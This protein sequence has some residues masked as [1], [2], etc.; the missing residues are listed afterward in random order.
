MKTRKKVLR[1]GYLEVNAP[2]CVTLESLA[3]RQVETVLV[4]I[5]EEQNSRIS[6][7]FSREDYLKR[8]KKRSR[9]TRYVSSSSLKKEKASLTERDFI[10]LRN[11]SLYSS[12]SQGSGFLLSVEST[13][14]LQPSFTERESRLLGK[15]S[16]LSFASIYRQ[17]KFF[18]NNT[19]HSYNE[20]LFYE[21]ECIYFSKVSERSFYILTKDETGSVQRFDFA[22]PFAT[23]TSL[24]SLWLDRF[25]SKL[26]NR[27]LMPKY[28]LL[29]V[30]VAAD[31]EQTEFEDL[32]EE[33]EARGL[34]VYAVSLSS[35]ELGTTIFEI[36]PEH[37][38]NE[39]SFVWFCFNKYFS[40]R[41]FHKSHFGRLLL[42]FVFGTL[43]GTKRDNRVKFLFFGRGAGQ[44]RRIEN[45]IRLQLLKKFEDIRTIPS[46]IFLHGWKDNSVTSTCEKLNE[47]LSQSSK[48]SAGSLEHGIVPLEFSMVTDAKGSCLQHPIFRIL[49]EPTERLSRL[50]LKSSGARS[51]TL[52]S[53]REFS[54][55]S[56]VMRMSLERRDVQRKY[57]GGVFW[58]DL[59]NPE[60]LSSKD[61]Q[62][63]KLLKYIE[64]NIDRAS[65][66]GYK[67][68]LLILDSLT[69]VE[70]LPMVF[71]AL[72]KM[73]KILHLVVIRSLGDTILSLNTLDNW[74][75]TSF[76]LSKPDSSEAE[77]N[78]QSND[79][80]F[81]AYE[82]SNQFTL[83]L[84]HNFLMAGDKREASKRFVT[85][86][87]K[88]LHEKR[89]HGINN[90]E[91]ISEDVRFR[92]SFLSFLTA[93]SLERHE[94]FSVS[95]VSVFFY[96]Q[97]QMTEYD[98][99]NKTVLA[100]LNFFS[101]IKVIHTARY[102]GQDIFC[103]KL[104]LREIFDIKRSHVVKLQPIFFP[105]RINE[106]FLTEKR[107]KKL[108]RKSLEQFFLRNSDL[109]DTIRKSKTFYIWKERFLE[110]FLRVDDY[111]TMLTSCFLNISFLKR[112][113]TLKSTKE[114]NQALTTAQSA[115][116]CACI[117]PRVHG[118][119]FEVCLKLRM[120]VAHLIHLT[121]KHSNIDP[122]RALHLWLEGFLTLFSNAGSGEITGRL[123]EAVLAFLKSI[124]GTSYNLEKVKSSVGFLSSRTGL[125]LKE[126]K[127][128]KCLE[129]INS[130]LALTQT[131]SS[132]SYDVLDMS[133]VL[134]QARTCKP[135]SSLNPVVDAKVINS[136]LLPLS[137]SP[138]SEGK[139]RVNK[140]QRKKKQPA[141]SNNSFSK[142]F[143]E[144]RSVNSM[145]I[146]RHEHSS[147]ARAR[148]FRTTGQPKT[149]LEIKVERFEHSALEACH[150]ETALGPGFLVFSVNEYYLVYS[151][152]TSISNLPTRKNQAV[153]ATQVELSANSQF[154][155]KNKKETKRRTTTFAGEMVESEIS[156]GKNARSRLNDATPANALHKHETGANF[157]LHGMGSSEDSNTNDFKIHFCGYFTL[158]KDLERVVG[159]K[160]MLRQKRLFVQVC[161]P[162]TKENYYLMARID[163]Y[164]NRV[165]E[166][167]NP[168]DLASTLLIRPISSRQRVS[169]LGDVFISKRRTN[170]LYLGILPEKGMVASFYSYQEKKEIILDGTFAK[171]VKVHDVSI[172]K[173]MNENSFLFALATSKFLSFVKVNVKK[174][175]LVFEI[176]SKQSLQSCGV[177]SRILLLEKRLY[178][179]TNRGVFYVEEFRGDLRKVSIHAIRNA[180]PR[181]VGLVDIFRYKDAF[182][183]IE[184]SENIL[185]ILPYQ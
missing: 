174:T 91:N 8:S 67:P 34:T 113:L 15:R 94:W 82:K 153:S 33:L 37:M 132:G 10:N 58:L 25:N 69:N 180:R 150:K 142:L 78:V 154:Q 99:V 46:P 149:D 98:G 112:M 162:D 137:S 136:A 165:Y 157:L 144:L 121:S 30:R 147:K 72:S 2:S 109:F 143:T 148:L 96:K 40:L 21:D 116:A 87:A 177:P 5:V 106:F 6:W 7:S 164:P 77:V 88:A 125:V 101:S 155:E 65:N 28:D 71:Q 19:L 79:I 41:S 102:L 3:E 23:S 169:R 130:S 167:R 127:D 76:T 184:S 54:G 47:V 12:L 13:T 185:K 123:Q 55:K 133:E 120:L 35:Y 16:K 104:P 100:F 107:S 24:S 73:E 4:Y 152:S 63:V 111:G 115:L 139:P 38:F 70:P 158:P 59:I 90:M 27:V 36:L 108:S 45:D 42:N 151:F 122:E 43:L 22:V 140:S 89:L 14:Q 181:A 95:D 50:L 176:Q 156:R 51:I 110:M 141:V 18:H 52:V 83:T 168:C 75:F 97:H 74:S 57:T 124:S 60:L 118:Y 129:Q 179:S 31:L 49:Q 80:P 170:Q 171:K 9:A 61:S 62:E 183:G 175:R 48:T 56:S 103:L 20:I 182:F 119:R 138:Q 17:N 166:V 26:P 105:E 117:S 131:R 163:K 126:L 85:E 146:S 114:L 53:G 145:D 160:I 93:L 29:L 11:S 161:N 135:I 84:L 44:Q 32:V 173:E 92:A 86:R 172:I 66:S 178:V 81:A 1:L 68:I 39:S 159:S 128:W 134:F 64:R